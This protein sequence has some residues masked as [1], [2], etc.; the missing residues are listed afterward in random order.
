MVDRLIRRLLV[1]IAIFVIA[2]NAYAS[3]NLKKCEGISTSEGFKWVGTY[4]VDFACSYVTTRMVDAY[5][6]YTI[7]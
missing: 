5:C 3:M 4:C 7:D 2:S 6:P 1:S